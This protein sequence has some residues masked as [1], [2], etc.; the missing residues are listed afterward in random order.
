MKAVVYTQYGPPDVLQLKEIDKPV[1]K[2]NEV[3]IK[4][5]ATT[6]TSGE[7]RLRKADPFAVRFV[8]GLLKPRIT[9]LGTELAGEVES[10]GKDVTRFKKGDPVFSQAL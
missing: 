1:P 5:Q 4:I 9:I 10:V 7:W 6:V 3:L 2:D 8:S